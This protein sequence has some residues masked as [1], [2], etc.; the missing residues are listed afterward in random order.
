MRWTQCS[1]ILTERG[2]EVVQ[3][4]PHQAVDFSVSWGSFFCFSFVFRGVCSV[5]FSCFWLSIPAEN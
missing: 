3:G 2:P 4:V 1:T 5:L